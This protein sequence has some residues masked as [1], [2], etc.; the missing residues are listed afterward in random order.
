IILL[1]GSRSLIPPIVLVCIKACKPG[2][3]VA[4]YTILV[5]TKGA[6]ERS[7][8]QSFTR[9]IL[10][11]IAWQFFEHELNHHSILLPISHMR[12]HWQFQSPVVHAKFNYTKRD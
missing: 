4:T 11:V 5:T 10:L 6:S 3:Q 1:R 7:M 2:V 12:F 9:L 8:C